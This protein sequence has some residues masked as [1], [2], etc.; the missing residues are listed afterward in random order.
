[1]HPDLAKAVL[2]L[3]MRV[4]LKGA[5]APNFMKVVSALEALA[6]PAPLPPSDPQ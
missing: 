6:N 1:M 3:L 5:E 4:D 2:Q